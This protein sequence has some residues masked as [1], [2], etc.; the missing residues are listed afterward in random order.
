[1]TFPV[2]ISGCVEN[3]LAVEDAVG[4]GKSSKSRSPISKILF[5]PTTP[6]APPTVLM[7]LLFGLLPDLFKHFLKDMGNIQN[8]YWFIIKQNQM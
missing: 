8:I 7:L 4:V 6:P 1:M 3:Q 2:L 5:P